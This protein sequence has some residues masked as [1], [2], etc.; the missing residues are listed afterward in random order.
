[1]A[2]AELQNSP[3]YQQL[4]QQFG[5]QIPPEQ[6]QA[7]QEKLEEEAALDIAEMTELFTQTVEQDLQIDPLVQLRQKELELKEMD[8]ERKG[9]EFQQRLLHDIRSDDADIQ[10]DKERLRLQEKN[11]DERTEIA[12]ERIDVQ[13]EK[14]R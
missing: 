9:Q 3:E 10:V 4:M 12:Q 5:G 2:L 8:Q 7:L 14:Q 13:R 11:I 6:Q 1:M